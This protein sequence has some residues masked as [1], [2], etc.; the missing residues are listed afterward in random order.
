[1]TAQREYRP[2]NKRYFKAYVKRKPHKWRHIGPNKFN[3]L[4]SSEYMT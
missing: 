3:D 4:W 1:M 2:K